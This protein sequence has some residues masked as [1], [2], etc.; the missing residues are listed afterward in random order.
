MGIDFNKKL[1]ILQ[2]DYYR[3]SL[4]WSRILPEGHG[5][6]NQ[7]GIDYYNKLINA[8][9][10]EGIEPMVCKLGLHDLLNNLIHFNFILKENTDYFPCK[11]S[12]L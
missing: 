2:A 4:S 8:L 10:R 9:I 3:F 6:I 5:R 11:L 1:Y 12:L 7:R